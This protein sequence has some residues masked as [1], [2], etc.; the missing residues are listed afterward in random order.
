MDDERDLFLRIQD[1]E[2]VDHGHL[3]VRCFIGNEKLLV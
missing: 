3:E 2:E 1:M